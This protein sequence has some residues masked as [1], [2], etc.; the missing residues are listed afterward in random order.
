MEL[1]GA[2]PSF[3]RSQTGH[4]GELAL[5][6][7]GCIL[8]LLSAW[9][10]Q[11]LGRSSVSLF[12]HCPGAVLQGQPWWSVPPGRLQ[13]NPQTSPPGAGGPSLLLASPTVPPWFLPLPR[14]LLLRGQGCQAGDRQAGSRSAV[15]APQGHQ[16][17]HTPVISP[18]LHSHFPAGSGTQQEPGV[19]VS[20]TRVTLS[21][22]LWASR[23]FPC[24]TASCPHS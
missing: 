19:G 18:T 16:H 6:Q 24:P 13:T 12:H 20:P 23:L 3:W 17:R 2:S 10:L 9:P 15:P 21:T 8:Q 14:L 4:R 22:S 1:Q 5:S 11:P 7:H